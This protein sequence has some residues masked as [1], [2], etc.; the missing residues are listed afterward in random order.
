M[1]FLYIKFFFIAANTKPTKRLCNN[2]KKITQNDFLFRDAASNQFLSIASSFFLLHVII[3][4]FS[5]H[6]SALLAPSRASCRIPGR[7]SV[8]SLGKPFG[9]IKKKRKTMVM[10]YSTLCHTAAFINRNVYLSFD[11]VSSGVERSSR[12]VSFRYKF[13]IIRIS[14]CIFKSRLM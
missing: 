10:L 6:F 5:F 14:G 2:E 12:D 1:Y 13:A 11:K 3:T 7:R 9:S 4:P 8:A